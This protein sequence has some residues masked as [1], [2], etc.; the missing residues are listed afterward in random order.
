[1]GL[2][3]LL[4]RSIRPPDPEIPNDNDAAEAF[5]NTVGPPDVNP[6]D[7]VR[8]QVADDRAPLLAAAAHD[9]PLLLVRLPR[10]V[11]PD[12]GPGQRAGGH[13]LGLYR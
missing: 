6:G 8:V 5:P 12:L 4:T 7:P 9:R 10:G 13:G 3:N 1:M 2:T 11:G